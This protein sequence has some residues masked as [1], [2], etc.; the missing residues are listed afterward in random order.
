MLREHRHE[1]Y[2]APEARGANRQA[3]LCP[4]HALAELNQTLEGVLQNHIQA[5]ERG[6]VTVLESGQHAL[7]NH[8]ELVG[9]AV[10]TLGGVVKVSSPFE[11]LVDYAVE[12][13]EGKS[14]RVLY[15]EMR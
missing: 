14:L 15:S 13:L 6:R 8:P 12:F 9:C 11:V 1:P 2:R 3:P 4:F 5:I 10:Q 7:L